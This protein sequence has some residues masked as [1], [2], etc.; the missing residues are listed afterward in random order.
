QFAKDMDEFI[1]S[2]QQVI[3]RAFDSEDYE[4]RRQQALSE[5]QRRRETLTTEL[6]TFATERGFT[7]QMT[8]AG[9]VTIPIV[10]GQPIS[11]DQYQ[12]LPEKARRNTKR[13]I[14]KCSGR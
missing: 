6:Q 14:S 13:T 3:P 7:L 8:Q 2:A 1:S 10:D 9:I 4:Q 11:P 5:I 12:Q